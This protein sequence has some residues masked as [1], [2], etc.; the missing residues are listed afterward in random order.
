M[1][2]ADGIGECFFVNEFG[3][4]VISAILVW[5]KDLSF[6]KCEDGVLVGDLDPGLTNITVEICLLGPDAGQERLGIGSFCKF[7]GQL[8]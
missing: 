7:R 1:A 5:T 4:A 8:G 2:G 6:L 3:D